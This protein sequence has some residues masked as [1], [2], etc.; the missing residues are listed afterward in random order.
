[1]RP[2]KTLHAARMQ[3]IRTRRV[4]DVLWLSE[5]CARTCNASLWK[6]PRLTRCRKKTHANEKRRLE[7]RSLAGPRCTSAS[8]AASRVTQ[9][10]RVLSEN[11]STYYKTI[12]V[13]GISW[14]YF[15]RVIELVTSAI[16]G[17]GRCAIKL[18]VL[19]YYSVV[20]YFSI[21]Y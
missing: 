21:V 17:V 16:T 20:V 2:P 3:K 12:T 11:H 18:L 4:G 1:M 6:S 15:R 7:R 14:V 9:P 8:E 5:T 10:L 19:W 13:L